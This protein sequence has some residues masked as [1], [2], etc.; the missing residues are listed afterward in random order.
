MLSF[1]FYLIGTCFSFELWQVADIHLDPSYIPHSDPLKL[2]RGGKGTTSRFGDY[3]CDA[4]QLLLTSLTKFMNENTEPNGKALVFTGDMVSRAIPNYNAAYV[5]ESIVNASNFLKQFQDFFIIPVLGNHDVYPANQMAINSQWLF[6]YAADVYSQF[7]TPDAKKSFQHGGYYTMPFPARFGI[8]KPLNAVVLNTVLY[9]NY[10]KQTVDGTDPLGQFEWFDSLM[11]GYRKTGQKALVS[12]HICPGVAERF[13]YSDQLY[14]QYNDRLVDI[15]AEYSDV[16]IGVLC[17]HLHTDTYRI[18]SK[19]NK[20]VVAFICPS[21]DT[22]LGTSP[23]VRKYDVGDGSSYM[24]GYKNYNFLLKQKL[25][26]EAKFE[27]HTSN[28]DYNKWKFNYDTAS[29]YGLKELSPYE[30]E[31]LSQRLENDLQLFN[32]YHRHFRG[33]TPGFSCDGKCKSNCICSVRHPR[34]TEFANCVMWE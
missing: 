25:T 33:D 10:N 28:Q 5:K 24:K 34:Q 18:I 4:N 14:P 9:Y 22:W 26:P 12:M 27:V 23:S 31:I 1:L 3:S 30:Y 17:G 11:K 2:C 32:K 6:N 13:N 20:K 19:G 8:T 7:L 15:L 29:Q 21:V 16:I